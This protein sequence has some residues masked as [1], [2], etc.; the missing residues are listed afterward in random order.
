MDP[1]SLLFLLRIGKQPLSEKVRFSQRAGSSLISGGSSKLRRSLAIGFLLHR[2]QNVY[3]PI[4]SN[5]LLLKS[6][7]RSIDNEA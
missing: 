3:T 6:V 4:Y 2:V 7:Y 1:K 5:E